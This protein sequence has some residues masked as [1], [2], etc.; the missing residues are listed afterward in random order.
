MKIESIQNLAT[1]RQDLRLADI[2]TQNAMTSQPSSRAQ[3]TRK[4]Y[5]RDAPS[6]ETLVDS[7]KIMSEKQRGSLSGFSAYVSFSGSYLSSC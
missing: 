7:S 5:L 1:I 4:P 3:A 2:D 6:E